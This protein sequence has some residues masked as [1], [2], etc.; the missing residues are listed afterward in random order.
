MAKIPTC[1]H[2][3]R[4]VFSKGR[5]KQCADADYARERQER[6]KE[7]RENGEVP[8]KVNPISDTQK[9]FNA[10][11][12]ILCA[13]LKPLHTICDGYGKIHGCTHAATEIHHKQGRR[14]ALLIMSKKFAY[15]CRHCHDFCTI[16]SA[17]AQEIGLSI[18]VNSKI[19]YD[20]TDRELQLI[21]IFQV[22][23]P[24]DALYIT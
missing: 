7:K 12:E 23:L 22:R 18:K 1:G 13:E 6:Q 3:D 15:L 20:F 4:P 8:T 19:E 11:Y 24:K 5:C 9:I 21:R 17:E 16:N 14:G 2:P 10:I